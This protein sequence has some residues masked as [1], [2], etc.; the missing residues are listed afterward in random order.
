MS[1]DRDLFVTAP[2]GTEELLAEELRA[3]GLARVRPASAGAHAQGTLEDAYRACL[4]SRVASRVLLPLAD[5]D[6][7]TADSLYVSAREVDWTAHTGPDQTLAVEVSSVRAAI[8]HTG[9]AGLKL[10]DAIVD[11][12]REAT[13]ERPSVDAE[14]PQV[15]FNLH[16]R[17]KRALVSLDLS[18]QALHRRGYRAGGVEAPIK[19]NLA[20]A[21]LLRARW[22]EMAAAGGGLVDPMCGSGTLLVEAAWMAADVAPGLLRGVHGSP[23]WRKHDP[24]TWARLVEDARTRRDAG[25]SKLPALVGQDRDPRA[26]DIA[27]ECVERA[28]L[29]EHVTLTCADIETVR[30]NAE[31]GL[32]ISN[33]PYGV[34][35]G[36]E[37]ELPALYDRLGTTLRQHFT[38]WTAA[39]LLGEPALGQH[40]GM[41]ASRRHTFF[42]GPIECRLLRFDIDRAGEERKP[43]APAPESEAFANRLRKNRRKLAAWRKRESIEA[44]RLYDADLPEYA[45]AV[46]LYGDH[47]HVQ[48]YAPPASVDAERARARLRDAVARTVEVLELPRANVHVKKRRRQRGADQYERMSEEA[49][50][51]EVREGAARLL[52]NLTQ[53]LD[54][55]L[56]LDHRKTRAM[57]GELAK[58]RRFLNLYCYTAA[59]TVHAA[60]GGATEST[61]VDL[62]NTYLDW[63]RRNLEL[64]GIDA[65]RHRLV[66]ADCAE[67]LAGQ[68]A[69]SF[70]LCFLDPPTFSSSK[71]MRGTLDIQRDHPELIRA[72]MRVLTPAGTLVF[73]TN[74]RKFGLDAQLGEE[75]AVEDINAR[76][77]PPDFERRPNVHRCWRI[78]RAARP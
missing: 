62:S 57:L 3:L 5:C 17:E 48:E 6:A 63:A 11:A 64:N 56:F 27:R 51:L 25:R 68:R 22:P 59:A 40:L 58:G 78:R 35:L 30:P 41:W 38:G 43:R 7:S 69:G 50:E 14:R 45:V 4:W 15:L 16:L 33:P 28:G 46:D 9:F 44:Y 66:R 36:A 70:D 65:A 29:S 37:S 60:L 24:D 55:G 67:W 2:R 39:L 21:V 26:V 72:A 61:S 74:R 31:R 32:L 76:T 20:A 23:G 73:S 49:V 47:A 54:T 34:R 10:K 12:I 8:E 42:N 75:F 52:V 18:G 13:G 71:R 77:L 53:Y 19:E 1:T